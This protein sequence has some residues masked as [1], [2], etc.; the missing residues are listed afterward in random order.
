MPSEHVVMKWCDPC[1]LETE[2]KVEAV[3]TYTGG[4][5]NGE[6]RPPLFV[7]LACEEHR[8]PIEEM[9]TLLKQCA[10]LTAVAANPGKSHHKMDAKE[11]SIRQRAAQAGEFLTSR[12]NCPVCGMEYAS[13]QIAG[14]IWMAH[15]GRPQGR[16]RQPTQCPD[17]AYHSE[18]GA[19]M[20]Q[21]RVRAHSYSAVA[22]AV[23]LFKKQQ[24][25]AAS[26]ESEVAGI[27]KAAGPATRRGRGKAAAA[28]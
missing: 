16:P 25:D 2:T 23:E 28:S 6:V 3:A 20:G 11:L 17:C 10:P 12:D 1:F 22:E 5:S 4:I 8:Q 13:S 14:H 15:L 26:A 18:L 24:D 7:V 19:A 9:L 21:H 27:E